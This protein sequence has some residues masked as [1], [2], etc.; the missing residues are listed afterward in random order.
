MQRRIY[1]M[2][3]QAPRKRSPKIKGSPATFIVHNCPEDHSADP[4][5]Y[6]TSR[7]RLLDLAPDDGEDGDQNGVATTCKET[8]TIYRV[9]FQRPTPQAAYEPLLVICELPR[10]TQVGLGVFTVKELAAGAFVIPYIGRTRISD[11]QLTPENMHNVLTCARRTWWEDALQVAEVNYGE[12]CYVLFNSRPSAA[13]CY[14]PAFEYIN[15]YEGIASRPNCAVDEFGGLYTITG[16]PA[17]T[18]LTIEYWSRY[19]TEADNDLPRLPEAIASKYDEVDYEF[20]RTPSTQP[21][22]VED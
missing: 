10:F 4:F 14:S 2:T 12:R 20:M 18:E 1:D 13:A 17:F 22:Q 3:A 9:V 6:V 19:T 8:F 15:C 5:K 7:A 21:M 16:V 11:A